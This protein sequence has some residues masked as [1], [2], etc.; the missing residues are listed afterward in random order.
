MIIG[1]GTPSASFDFNNNFFTGTTPMPIAT[2]WSATLTVKKGTSVA[3]Q[4]STLVANEGEVFDMKHDGASLPYVGEFFFDWAP[5]PGTNGD[6]LGR[7]DFYMGDGCY[8]FEVEIVN[9]LGETFV[10]SS[11]R[12]EFFW[13]SN[14][15]G[16]GDESATAC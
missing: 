9:V 16:G 12:I 1:I 5:M 2:D 3:Y 6:Q 4:Y 11:S 10:D 15:G 7:D 13:E 14:E 8:T